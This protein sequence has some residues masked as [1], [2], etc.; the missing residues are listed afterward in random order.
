MAT[1]ATDPERVALSVEE[2]AEA[3]GLG[4]TLMFQLIGRGEIRSFKCGRRRLVPVDALREW[5]Q[6]QAGG[7]GG[8]GRPG[9]E[10]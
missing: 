4:R 5:V 7:E 10:R 9:A 6:R 8:T 2:A 1:T 3:A